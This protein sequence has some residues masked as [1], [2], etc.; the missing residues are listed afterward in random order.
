MNK[1]LTHLVFVVSTLFLLSLKSCANSETL[2][3]GVFGN[4]YHWYFIYPGKDNTLHTKD[5]IIT[6]GELHLP[7]NRTVELILD[8]SDYLY[9]FKIPSLNVGQIAIPSIIQ[10]TTFVTSSS[11]KVKIEG[12]Q[13]CGLL[14][15][16]LMSSLVMEDNEDFNSWLKHQAKQKIKIPKEKKKRGKSRAT[17]NIRKERAFDPPFLNKLGDF[18]LTDQNGKDFGSEELKGRVWI[19]NF[20]FTRCANTCPIQ[21]RQLSLLQD[22]LK[23]LDIPQYVKLISFSIDSE[24]DK[25]AVLAEY[26]QNTQ[27]NNAHW[28]FLTGDKEKIWSLGQKEFNLPIGK[29]QNDEANLYFHSSKFILIDQ[30]HYIRGYFNSLDKNGIN[31]LIAAIEKI[32][33]PEKSATMQTM[34]YPPDAV[35]LAELDK[36]KKDQ[37]NAVKDIEI[38]SDFIFENKLKDSNIAFRHRIVDDGG[39]YHKAVHYD[40]GNGVS[41]ADI[42]LDGYFDIY[43]VNQ[44]G[45]NQLWRNKGDGT[46]ENITDDAGVAVKDAISVAASFA[47]IDNDGDDD[48]YVTIVMEGNRLFENIGGRFKDISKASGTNHVAHSSGA[49]F[50]DY[51]RDGL[52]DLFLTNVGRYT[53]DEK[54]QVSDDVT[55][56]YYE[57]GSFNYYVGQNNAFAGHLNPDFNEINRLFK[58]KGGGQFVD[59][60]DQIGLSDTTWSGDAS[61]S[62]VDRDGWLDL[63]VLNMQGDDQ[64]Y[65]NNEG[66]KFINKTEQFFSKTPWGSMGIKFFDYNNDQR[67]DLF[68]TDMHSDMISRIEYDKEKTKSL[69]PGMDSYIATEGMSIL[70]NAF[71]ERKNGLAFQEVSDQI[72]A[73]NYWPWGFSVDDIN[74]DGY[75]DVFIASSMNYPFRY[76]VNSMLLNDRGSKFVDAA[77][78]LNIEPRINNRLTTAWFEL[79]CKKTDKEHKLCQD[80]QDHFIV[81]ATLGTRSSAIVDIDLDGDLDI[82]TNDF[83][84]EPM[85]LISNLSEKKKINYLKIKLKGSKSNKSGIGAVVTV[86]AG[87][88]TSMKQNDGKSGYLSQSSMPLYFGLGDYQS[89]DEI[90]ILWPSG[91]K[92]TVEGPVQSNQLITISENETVKN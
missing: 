13:L 45:S 7:S 65:I 28:K 56:L 5:D 82:I 91:T 67:F 31:E 70:G 63:Y 34:I 33:A 49:V 60:T 30:N 75:E 68:I 16:G 25:P 21:T 48:L 35:E 77:F 38:Y 39:K 17:K 87:N 51:N 85:I 4:N 52:L 27:A 8:S 74:A 84:S 6:D 42:D 59:V 89:A 9:A 3:V 66:T 78:V 71:Y 26:A 44:V 79:D 72:G 10:K 19:A 24:F 90:E 14:H 22:R 15:P 50:F 41:I 55:T 80:R 43:F 29:N 23:N 57:E 83:N 46:F 54:Q 36:R 53:H 20:I 47:D 88:L 62:D 40:H 2:K 18:N 58:N 69:L 12:D 32:F 81:M 1:K 11:G 61:V 37:Y 86:K 76:G 92:Q 73:E 64:F